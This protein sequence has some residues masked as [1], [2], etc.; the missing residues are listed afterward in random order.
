MRPI[1]LLIFLLSA[2]IIY[3]GCGSR[4]NTI[5]WK[6][7]VRLKE[8]EGWKYEVTFGSPGAVALEGYGESDTANSL[9]GYWAE[10]GE[11]HTNEFKQ[12]SRLYYL[13]SYTKT[14]GD[15]FLVVLSKSKA[16]SK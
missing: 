7:D 6:T 12:D 1:T 4:E 15:A 2:L 13:L 10:N 9:T 5:D 8:K 16:A 14:N 3:P 11:R